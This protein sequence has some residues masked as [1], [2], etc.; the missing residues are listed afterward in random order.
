[1]SAVSEKLSKTE[2]ESLEDW[3]AEVLKAWSQGTG[4]PSAHLSRPAGDRARE[5]S[6]RETHRGKITDGSLNAPARSALGTTLTGMGA[7]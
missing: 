1:M 6:L 2:R 3:I 7:N 5:G 4:S